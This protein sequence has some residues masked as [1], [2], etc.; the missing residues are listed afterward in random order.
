MA[1]YSFLTFGVCDTFD[2]YIAASSSK[3]MTDGDFYYDE[4]FYTLPT[5]TYYIVFLNSI[6]D[7]Y[8]D[9]YMFYFD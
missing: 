5:G 4:L 6:S 9:G 3:G 2:N 1:D 8:D 7:C